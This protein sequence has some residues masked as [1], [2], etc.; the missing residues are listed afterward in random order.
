MGSEMCIR[1]RVWQFNDCWPG[2]SWSL[3]DFDRTC[4]AAYFAVKRAYAPVVASFKTLDDG[5]IELWVA[6]DTPGR[7][8]VDISLELA[9][10]A[11]RACWRGDVSADIAPHMS[12]PVWRA[13]AAHVA[14]APDRVLT[15]RSPQVPANRLL[16][17]PFKDLPLTD[18]TL[19]L[20]AL[21]RLLPG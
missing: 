7:M 5:G 20:R 2:I 13:D 1:D 11:G 15:L 12:R 19:Q 21:D 4:K 10:F 3:V 6:N 18:A 17:A 14:A 8:H 9:T 16:F